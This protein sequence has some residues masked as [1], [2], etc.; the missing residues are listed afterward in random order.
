MDVEAFR[1]DGALRVEGLF[2]IPRLRRLRT[3]RAEGAG[4]R[5]RG[6]WLP[7]LIAPATALASRLLGAR[8]FPVRAVLFDKSESANWAVP[9]HQDRTIPVENRIEVAGFGPWSRKDGALH[10]APPVEILRRMATLRIHIDPVD[11]DNAPLVVAA[12]SHQIGMTAAREAAEV[13]MRGAP[14]ICLASDGDI[15]AYATLI[16]HKSDRSLR[17]SRRRVLQVD[18]AA[19]K[20]PGGL[21]WSGVA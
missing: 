13:A 1:R 11:A 3:L 12:G 4:S 18:Y 17:P 14:I 20:L 19:D 6:P 15:W 21:S 5:L 7:S 9:W 8:A 2:D 16:L 10:V